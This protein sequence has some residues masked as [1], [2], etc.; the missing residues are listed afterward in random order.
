MCMPLYVSYL[1][2]LC[3][4]HT[5]A[6]CCYFFFINYKTFFRVWVWS[7]GSKRVRHSNSPPLLE[8]H[9]QTLNGWRG[10]VQSV[11]VN[12][13]QR[14]S[15][16]EEEL[17]IWSKNIPCMGCHSFVLQHS[18]RCCRQSRRRDCDSDQIYSLYRCSKVNT[19]D[20][21]A[22]AVATAIIYNFI[23]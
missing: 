22:G 19:S 12:S 16:H 5:R 1:N 4:I 9:G 17:G 21:G 6:H 3:G 2:L 8:T 7:K 11:Y 20:P 18:Y 15:Q 14:H 23:L 10:K 13:W